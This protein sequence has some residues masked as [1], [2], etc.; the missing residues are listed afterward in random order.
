MSSEILQFSMVVFYTGGCIF[1]IWLVTRFRKPKSLEI[2]FVTPWKEAALATGYVIGLFLALAV[3]FFFLVQSAGGPLG[4]PMQFDLPMA[5]RQWVTYAI[6][7]IIPVFVII[8]VRKHSFETIGVTKKNL[9][10]SFGIGLGLSLLIAALSITPEQFLNRFFSSNTFYAFIYFL[11]VGFGEELMFRGLLQLRC[12]SWLGE[13]KGFILAS[14]IMALVHI[15][16]RIFAVGLDPL[17]ALVSALSLM[18]F[19]LLMGF[20]MLRTRN[21]LGPTILHTINNWISVL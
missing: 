17:S 20:L 21:I 2:K 7:F 3:V 16:Q 15:P 13:I 11:A 1:L 12:S 18:P 19:S 6:M 4:T 9:W 14:T 5:L 8:K 10:L